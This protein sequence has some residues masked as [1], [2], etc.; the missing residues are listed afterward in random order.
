MS[1]RAFF[2]VSLILSLGAA[3]VAADEGD[4]IHLLPIALD[5]ELE[6][7]RAVFRQNLAGGLPPAGRNV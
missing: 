6:G 7:D 2:L 1:K 3:P 4:T 5:P